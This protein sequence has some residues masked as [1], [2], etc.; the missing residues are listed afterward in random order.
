MRLVNIGDPSQLRRR[1]LA[2]LS[3][4]EDFHVPRVDPAWLAF[5]SQHGE[6]RAVNKVNNSAS[7]ALRDQCSLKLHA[8][9]RRK[10]PTN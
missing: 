9:A 3:L 8:G 1:G 7:A 5:V 2:R 6:F 4:R 10:M